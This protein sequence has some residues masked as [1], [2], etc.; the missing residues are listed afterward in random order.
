MTM[1]KTL[2]WGL[3]PS[4]CFPSAALSNTG[5]H[6]RIAQDTKMIGITL[7]PAFCRQVKDFS[8]RYIAS[9][10]AGRMP[11]EAFSAST[12]PSSRKKSCSNLPSSSSYSTPIPPDPGTL[13]L[14]SAPATAGLVPSVW[15]RLNTLP[16]PDFADGSLFLFDCSLASASR[17]ITSSRIHLAGQSPDALRPDL[18]SN[19]TSV[20]ER[21]TSICTQDCCRILTSCITWRP[22]ALTA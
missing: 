8:T 15:V 5:T 13:K 2:S 22:L 4:A 14:P 18:S 16:P 19:L 11:L 3:S 21:S 9:T 12:C 1:R 7:L 10:V 17:T 6:T 20:K